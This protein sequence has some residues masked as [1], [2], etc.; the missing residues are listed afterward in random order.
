MKPARFIVGS[1]AVVASLVV[2]FV[3]AQPLGSPRI[4]PLPEFEWSEATRDVI[5]GFESTGMRHLAATYAN[6]E[7][8]AVASLPHL[9][10]LWTDSVLPPRA[11]A[12]LMLR[13][14]WL[15]ESEY[16]WAH[17]AALA[18]DARRDRGRRHL[19]PARCQRRARLGA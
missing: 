4:D 18:R 17:R 7:E 2:A 6:R 3:Q 14:A 12:L 19:Q 5:A 8:V 10:Y 11:R 16:L 13:T 1:G 9:A 15:A